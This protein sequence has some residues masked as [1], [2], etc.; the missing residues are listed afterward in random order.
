MDLPC[1]PEIATMEMKTFIHRCLSNVMVLTT[2]NYMAD[3]GIDVLWY[4]DQDGDG[5]GIVES[6]LSDCEQPNPAFVSNFGDCSPTEPDIH[7]SAPEVCDGIDHNCDGLIDYDADEDGYSDINCGGDDCDDE[8]TLLNPST[9][10]PVGI[11]CFDIYQND[12]LF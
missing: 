9:G 12:Y 3:E 1:S 7:P 11:D 2:I 10:C 8:N 4:Y 5:Y 6:F